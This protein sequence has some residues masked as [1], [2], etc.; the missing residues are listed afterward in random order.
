L[1]YFDILPSIAFGI[2]IPGYFFDIKQY[3]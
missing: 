2:R 3:L 1:S